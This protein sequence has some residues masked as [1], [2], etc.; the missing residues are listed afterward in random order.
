MSNESPASPEKA[1]MFDC[2]IPAVASIEKC[3]GTQLPRFAGG[4]T[5]RATCELR[6]GSCLVNFTDGDKK[7]HKLLDVPLSGLSQYSVRDV[8]AGEL[9]KARLLAGLQV[10]ALLSVLFIGG[11]F[12]KMM[13][14]DLSPR[15]FMFGSMAAPPIII[16][17]TVLIALVISAF[18]FLA[19]REIREFELFGP[20]GFVWS[21]RLLQS[22]CE[23]SDP[24]L[25]RDGIAE[26]PRGG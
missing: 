8:T 7:T 25:K 21:F 13:M 14:N 22:D 24:L 9:T 5:W 11:G 12:V 3:T 15:A 16:A 19:H 1:P 17:A 26:K 18:K 20:E 6:D 4:M 2:I 23:K 10:G